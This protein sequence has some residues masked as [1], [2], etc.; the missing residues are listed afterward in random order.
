MTDQTPVLSFVIPLYNSAETIRPLVKT[1]EQLAVEGGHEIVLVND[2]S[3]D[4]TT[5]VC[6]ALVSE[7]RVP[8]TLI[9]HARNFGEHNAVLTGWRHARGIHI[10]N[11][12]DDGQNPPAEAVR[13]WLHAK[14]A[15]LDVV[16]G[17]Y[18]HKKHSL[19]RNAGSWFTNRMTDWALDKPAGFYL[20]SF[21]CVT[22][23]VAKAATANDGPFPYIDGL[24]LQTT[25]R[26]GSLAVEHEQRQAGASGYTLRKLMRLWASTF[27]NFSIMPLRIA[28]IIGLGMAVAGFAGI[29]VVFYWWLTEKGPAFGWG[30]LMAALLTF[31]GVQLVLLGVIGEYIGRMFLTVNQRP[32]SLV[33][34]V[35]KGG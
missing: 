23:F 24:L 17:H 12:D 33:R 30:M 3:R 35:V 18:A 8:I 11:I 34:E 1:I 5:D 20:S 15:N 29:G 27:I 21:R 14:T 9:E 7:A 13:L 22:A 4:A 25:Q 6:R 31:S 32:Q 2:G 28:T 16:Y 10:V 26:I 19:W